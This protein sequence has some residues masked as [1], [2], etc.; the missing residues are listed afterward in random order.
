MMDWSFHLPDWRER[1]RDGRPLVK[2]DLPIDQME[3]DRAVAIFNRLR[4]PDV[5]GMPTMEEAAGDWFR[6]ILRALFGSV[7]A[8]G[9]RRVADVFLLVPKKNSKTTSG[10]ALMLAAL[11]MNRRP[12]AKF[13][14]FGP[15]QEVADIAF[16][17]LSGMIKADPTLSKLIHV[18]EHLKLVEHRVTHATLKITTFDMATATGGKYAGWLL[19]EVHLLGSVPYAARVVDQLRGARVA[20]PESFGVMITTQSDVAPAGLFKDELTQ[21]RAVRDGAV[22]GGALLP[23]LYEFDEAMQI[24]PSKPWA[25]PENWALVNPN[26]GRSVSVAAI[27]QLHDAAKARGEEAFRRFASQ[28]LNVQI[29]AALHT[30]RWLGTDYWGAA[31]MGR[32]S[33]EEMLARCEVA[34]I[35]VDGGGLDDLLGLYVIGRERETKRWLAWAKAWAD[36]GVLDL[37]KSIAPQLESFARDGD[38]SFVDLVAGADDVEE[39]ADIVEQVWK[40]GLLPEKYGI[41]LDPAGVAALT[42]AIVRRG[43]PVECL[44]AVSQGW[45]LTGVQKGAA[46]KLK[47]GSLVPMAQPMSAWCAANAKTEARGNAAVITKAASGTAKIDP[48]MALFCAFDLMSRNPEPAFAE[49]AYEA[50]ELMVI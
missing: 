42:D 20:I 7:D 27:V 18:R 38:L 5:F 9:R 40:A 19:D 43:V 29:G 36:R 49:S 23:V 30:D 47:D 3:A 21:A 34:T 10:A 1:L 50:E 41:G 26:V 31:C 24:D 48:L 13:A 8:T 12:Q 2:E 11:L 28:H 17:A 16:E 4:V 15:T 22:D 44:A 6:A 35:G 14:L 32:T 25:D 45:R 46:R 39:V 33:L 37:R